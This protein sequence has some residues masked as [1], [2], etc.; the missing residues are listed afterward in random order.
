VNNQLRGAYDSLHVNGEPVVGAALT[1]DKRQMRYM[2]SIGYLNYL[3][4]ANVHPYSTTVA[5]QQKVISAAR[6][7]FAGRPITCTEWN[8]QFLQE[9]DPAW[10]QMLKE[11]HEFVKANLE[12]AFYF[13]LVFGRAS[14]DYMGGLVNRDMTPH[15]PFFDTYMSFNLPTDA[16]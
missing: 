8:F 12:S 3:D 14:T 2:A 4:Y 1:P 7:I 9:K 16:A 15:Q 5:Q 13:R 6:E 10:P 11:Q